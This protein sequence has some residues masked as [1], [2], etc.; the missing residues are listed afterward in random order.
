MELYYTWNYIEEKDRHAVF[1]I[2]LM[3]NIG[4][5]SPSCYR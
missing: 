3:F 2:G 5:H 1:Y 4:L